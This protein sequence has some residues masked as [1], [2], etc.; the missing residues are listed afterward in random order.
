VCEAAMKERN[1]RGGN[2]NIAGILGALTKETKD[3]T[4]EI[5]A[6]MTSPHEDEDPQLYQ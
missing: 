1:I 3:V 2:K 5:N 4:R 6:M